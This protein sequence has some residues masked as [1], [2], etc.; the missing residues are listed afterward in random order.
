[1][2]LFKLLRF[3]I[4]F[5]TSLLEHNLTKL[6]CEYSELWEIIKKSLRFLEKVLRVHKI[7]ESAVKK[8]LQKVSLFP[9]HKT[10]P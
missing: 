10:W 4:K 6:I 1:M 8:A 3:L 7:I 5:S 9:A 2:F